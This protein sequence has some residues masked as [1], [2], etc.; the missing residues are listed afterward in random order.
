LL[1]SRAKN[2]KGIAM[3]RPLS[4]RISDLSINSNNSS[5]GLL[6]QALLTNIIVSLGLKIA[7]DQ[8]LLLVCT[9]PN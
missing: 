2:A 4:S 8:Q 9:E 5:N 6:M 1:E 7:Y 3:K